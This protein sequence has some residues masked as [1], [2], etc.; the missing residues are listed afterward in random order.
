[1]DIYRP[2]DI[3]IRMRIKGTYDRQT[4]AIPY[5]RELYK[6]ACPQCGEENIDLQD[7]DTHCAYCGR[8]VYILNRDYDIED[9]GWS[10]EL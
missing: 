10:V 2:T 4:D 5:P 6:W 8:A 3:E 1:M 7:Q 9:Q